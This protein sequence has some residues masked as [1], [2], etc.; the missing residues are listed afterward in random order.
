MKNKNKII[1]FILILLTVFTIC[2]A[3]FVPK[4][5]LNRK[6]T[7]IQNKVTAAPENYY[8]ASNT[9]MAKK[10]SELLATYEKTNLITG[11]WDNVC[12]KADYQDA[13]LKESDAVALAKQKIDELNALELYPYSLS[14]SYNNWYS[15]TTDLY[16]FTDTNFNTYTCYLWIITFT[17]FDN[18]LTHTILM[19]EDGV[20]LAGIVNDNTVR[21]TPMLVQLNEDS[22][23]SILCD[24][25]IRLEN[26]E[27]YSYPNF[28]NTITK[29]Y[30]DNLISG[31]TEQTSIRVSL[32]FNADEPSDYLVYQTKTDQSYIFG[33]IPITAL[34][35]ISAEDNKTT[36]SL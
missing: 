7:N 4:Y 21:I 31:I 19:T 10:A 17:R 11:S 32:S 33:I 6:Y 9:A 16:S 12:Q 25:K 3:I 34:D 18:A 28:A 24:S 20:I 5:L 2:G 36:E 22:I 35:K 27:V 15:W 23:R 13:L 14:S 8:L 1:P 29:I 26:K 30:P